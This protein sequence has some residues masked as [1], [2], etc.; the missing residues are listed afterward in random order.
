MRQNNSINLPWLVRMAWR[1]SRR[2]R[3]RLFLF[4]SSIILGIAALVAV[5]SLSDNLQKEIDLQAAALL[6]AD[7]EISNGRPFSAAVQ[8]RI[9]SL[10]DRRSQ[11]KRFASMV[12][13]PKNGGTRIIEVR[14]LGGDFPYYGELETEPAAAGRRFRSGRQA[15]VDQTLMLQYNANIGDSVRIGKASFRIAGV[16][17]GAPGQTGISSAVAPVVYIP[18][19]ALPQTGLEQKGSRINYRYYV[20]WDQP[21]DV[22]S[23]EEGFRETFELE[24]VRWETVESQKEDT[25]RSFAD[26]TRFLSLVAFIALLLGC[27]GVASAIQIYIREKI[28]TIAVLRCLG[29]TARQAFLIYLIQVLVIGFIGS[30]IGAVL[31]TVVQQA[32]PVV[33]K[34]LLPV[35]V[36]TGISWT[37]IAQGVLLGVSISLLFALLPLIAVRKISPLNTIR[38]SFQ[39]GQVKTDP[40][41]W[42]VYGLILLFVVVFA[43]L[44][45]EGW[46]QAVAFTAAILFTYPGEEVE[47]VGPVKSQDPVVGWFLDRRGHR[48]IDRPSGH[49]EGRR[50]E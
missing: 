32:L 19:Q 29:T 25:A 35:T 17:L 43:Y 9:D 13:F 20:K 26:L 8:K 4:I 15:L 42:L 10:G 6:G 27:I 2:N 33:L 23:I 34:D 5:Y 50:N 18:I 49:P 48:G 12:F 3:S 40:L 44:Q 31:G 37:A 47:F 16:L 11:E 38:I 1:D 45:L 41:R 24:G 30:V 21:V 28:G 39:Q 14:A 46:L 22:K 7:L 36:T